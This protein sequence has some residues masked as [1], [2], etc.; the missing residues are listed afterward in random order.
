VRAESAEIARAGELEAANLAKEVLQEICSSWPT[1]KIS[2]GMLE[3]IRHPVVIDN[4]IAA[5]ELLRSELETTGWK[6]IKPWVLKKFYGTKDHQDEYSPP[7]IYE[8]VRNAKAAAMDKDGNE[9]L[10]KLPSP[11]ELK[12]RVLYFLTSEVA[13][14]EF[15]KAMYLQLDQMKSEHASVAESFLSQAAIDGFV[16]YEAH[17]SREFDRTLSQ[18]ERI[19]RMRLGQPVV[20]A[21]KV[22]IAP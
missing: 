2:K 14:L 21:I 15:E 22:D 6:S 20:P 12:S 5:L 1:E 4:A 9:N 11:N 16:C 10:D 17:L 8:T 7:N 13:A 3:R 18:L 19:Q